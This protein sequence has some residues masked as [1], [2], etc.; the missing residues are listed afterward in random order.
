[1][2]TTIEINPNNQLVCKYCLQNENETNSK[3]VNPCLCTNPVCIACLKHQIGLTQTLI[4]E[5]CKGSIIITVEMDIVMPK[6]NSDD[7]TPEDEFS[8]NENR[9]L[10]NITMCIPSVYTSSCPFVVIGVVMICICVIFIIIY[11]SL[12]A[13]K[14]IR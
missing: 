7:N 9:R 13:A 6:T 4:C 10:S 1:M 8:T 5:I 3:F 2:E 14:I 12:T 11:T